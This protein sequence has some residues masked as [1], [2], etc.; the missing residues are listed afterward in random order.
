MARRSRPPHAAGPAIRVRSSA[1]CGEKGGPLA[2]GADVR[3]HLRPG[4]GPCFGGPMCLTRALSPM[5]FP[6]AHPSWP[7]RQP[8]VRSMG[9]QDFQGCPRHAVINFTPWPG[10]GCMKQR[11]PQPPFVGARN[12]KPDKQANFPAERPNIRHNASGATRDAS[13]ELATA[14]KR[15]SQRH[16]PDVPSFFAHLAEGARGAPRN[17]GHRK[18]APT[19]SS[20]N[21][22]LSPPAVGTTVVKE[23]RGKAPSALDRLRTSRINMFLSARPLASSLQ[24]PRKD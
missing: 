22:R 24:E 19:A 10:R 15:S 8:I 3:P 18:D 9:S 12:N 20:H 4:C 2:N 23:G 6:R 7:L 13:N 5:A 14:T 21:E 17:A 11:R 1:R 16:P